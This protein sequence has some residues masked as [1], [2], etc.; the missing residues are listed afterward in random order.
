[1]LGYGFSLPGTL[2]IERPVPQWEIIFP[3][4]R[5][6]RAP[7]LASRREW[8]KP[9]PSTNMAAALASAPLWRPRC[10]LGIAGS[11]SPGAGPRDA[12]KAPGGGAGAGGV[13]GSGAAAE[14]RVGWGLPGEVTRRV[15]ASRA[16][17]SLL[18]LAVLGAA[19]EEPGKGRGGG[20][21]VRPFRGREGVGPGRRGGW[22]A[23]SRRAPSARASVPALAAGAV[24]AR[25][26]P[27]GPAVQVDRAGP[28]ARPEGPADLR[29]ARPGRRGLLR[30]VYLRAVSSEWE[31][32]SSWWAPS[33]FRNGLGW[34][35][36]Q[37]RDGLDSWACVPCAP[38]KSGGSRLKETHSWKS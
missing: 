29:P 22:R 16:R 25:A 38:G 5:W 13:R 26:C 4:A 31:R 35:H 1:M 36:M 17:A 7:A 3:G 23:P 33:V 21:A 32:E 24:G 14:A 37:V 10:R 8:E 28:D 11:A 12:G 18:A 6:P 15:P 20:G 2:G 30:G 19:G 27:T 34:R 9:L